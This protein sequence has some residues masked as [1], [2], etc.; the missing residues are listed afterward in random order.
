MHPVGSVFGNSNIQ[1]SD[2]LVI[3]QNVTINGSD[4]PSK[5]GK[6]LFLGAGSKII[7]ENWKPL[8]GRSQYVS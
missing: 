1:Y 5:L 6:Y 3:M 8:F 7:G 2:C 4:V